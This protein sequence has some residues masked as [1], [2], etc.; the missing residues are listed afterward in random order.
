MCVCV[1]LFV[2]LWGGGAGGGGEG[3]V[4]GGG[5]EGGGEVG[6]VSHALPKPTVD[7]Q[8]SFEL[9]DLHTC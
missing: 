7:Y 5:V 2:L 1:L 8:M 4:E 6:I 3:G 9:F